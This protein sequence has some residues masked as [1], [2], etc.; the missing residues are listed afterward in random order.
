LQQITFPRSNYSPR[1]QFSAL[2]VN[3]KEVSTFQNS[4][5]C[6]IEEFP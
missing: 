4:F 1:Q 6:P 3:A 2:N 5:N